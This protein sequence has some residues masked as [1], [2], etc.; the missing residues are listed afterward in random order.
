M[1][2]RLSYVSRIDKSFWLVQISKMWNLLDLVRPR[3]R[4]VLQN[5]FKNLSSNLGEFSFQTDPKSP[6]I[7]S[8]EKIEFNLPMLSDASKAR[9]RS[10]RNPGSVLIFRLFWSKAELFASNIKKSPKMFG[11]FYRSKQI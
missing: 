8:V 9:G 6:K 10:S 3:P 1:T 5:S 11:A 4:A 2:G 7:C